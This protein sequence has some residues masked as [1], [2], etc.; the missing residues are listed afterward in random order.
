MGPGYGFFGAFAACF[1]AN[2][3]HLGGGLR[4]G[5]V[6]RS[7]CNQLHAVSHFDEKSSLSGSVAFRGQQG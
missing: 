6:S 1:S 3:P 2:T 4:S 7:E 5:N